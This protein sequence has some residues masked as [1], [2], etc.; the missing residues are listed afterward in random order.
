MVVESVLKNL[1]LT[2]VSIELGEVEVSENL[3]KSQ[4]ESLNKSLQRYGFEL[5]DDRKGRVIESIKTVIINN[6]HHGDEMN[7]LTFSKLLEKEIHQEYSSLSK[8]FSEVQGITIEKFIISQKIERIKELLVYDE[9]SLSQIADQLN[10]SS[11]AHLSGQFK[12]F[13]GFTPSHFK[14]LR[15]ERKAARIPIEEI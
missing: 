12:K 14:A 11:V 2:A 9:F 5:I 7:G 10:Y 15:K 6:I 4:K 13:T 1:K 8:L 3:S